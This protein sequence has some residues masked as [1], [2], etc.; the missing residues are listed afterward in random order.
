MRQHLFDVNADKDVP[1]A[2]RLTAYWGFVLLLGLLVLVAGLAT[3]TLTFAYPDGSARLCGVLMLV[4]G[5]L[6]TALALLTGKPPLYLLDVQVN[7]L[8]AVVGL[9]VLDRPHEGAS[10]LPLIASALLLTSGMLRLFGGLAIGTRPGLGLLATGAWYLVW[11][12]VIWTQ[13]VH[14][15]LRSVGL[16]LAVEATRI[17]WNL[18]RAAAKLRRATSGP[19]L[20]VPEVPGLPGLETVPAESGA[21]RTAG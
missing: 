12:L 13:G 3:L 19:D 20:L 10:A 5:A 11:G 17:G 21:Y 7:F 9:L 15:G 18:C 14:L 6:G 1:T 2:S 16:L 8:I 4:G